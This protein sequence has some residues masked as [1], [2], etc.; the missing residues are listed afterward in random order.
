MY[1][2]DRSFFESLK[3]LQCADRTF[4]T[5]F[6]SGNLSEHCDYYWN[7]FQTLFQHNVRSSDSYLLRDGILAKLKIIRF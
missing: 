4:G 2:I 5:V 3:S 7:D 6:L 1:Y